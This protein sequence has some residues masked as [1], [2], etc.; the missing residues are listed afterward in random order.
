[1]ASGAI[2]DC[3]R[4][5]LAAT[6]ARSLALM[7]LSAPCMVPNAVR[8]A[9][10]MT[11]D[12]ENF[13]MTLLLLFETRPRAAEHRF[14]ALFHLHAERDAARPDQPSFG[15]QRIAGPHRALELRAEAG[16]LGGVA[17]QRAF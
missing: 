10:T 8:L 3:A 14:V 4:A 15:D 6:T 2:L 13:A 1:M 5:A 7:P 9:P 17:A 12:L 11:I 16:E